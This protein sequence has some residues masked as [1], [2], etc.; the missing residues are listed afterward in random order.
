M[1]VVFNI[2][3]I[4]YSPIRHTWFTKLCFVTTSV[5]GKEQA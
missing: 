5:M 2:M 1:R 3:H 4:S